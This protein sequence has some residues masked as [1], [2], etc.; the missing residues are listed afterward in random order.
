MSL[1]CSRG[2]HNI[3]FL[4]L[5]PTLLRHAKR[6]LP[7]WQELS[8]SS[9]WRGFTTWCL[10]LRLCLLRTISH[11]T[12]RASS[13]FFLFKTPCRDGHGG[14]ACERDDQQG[15]ERGK[16]KKEPKHALEPLLPSFAM[17]NSMP[18]LFQS[19]RAS[20][21]CRPLPCLHT[22]SFLSFFFHLIHNSSSFAACT[23]DTRFLEAVVYRGT[24]LVT[25][26]LCHCRMC[27]LISSLNS[28][29]SNTNLSDSF[30]SSCSSSS[31]GPCES[32]IFFVFSTAP[33]VHQA[34]FTAA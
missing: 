28:T 23:P 12:H 1:G 14:C 19:N 10:I 9:S 5:D 20:S 7:L 15:K 27:L 17:G 13:S 25:H 2:P 3:P 21:K 33:L 18:H 6:H 16:K 26:S 22:L 11:K 4:I 24:D 30:V 31:K 8:S 29:S 34:R 32:S